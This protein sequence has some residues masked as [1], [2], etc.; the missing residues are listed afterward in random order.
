MIYRLKVVKIL[1]GAYVLISGTQY[2]YSETSPSGAQE[3]NRVTMLAS[4]ERFQEASDLLKDLIAKQHQDPESQSADNVRDRVYYRFAGYLYLQLNLLSE[5]EESFKAIYRSH[6]YRNT[7]N[8]E[9]YLQVLTR[10]TLFLW[11]ALKLQG[12]HG[13]ADQLL[14]QE[15]LIAENKRQSCYLNFAHFL[16]GK[17]DS[18]DL[19]VSVGEPLYTC[20]HFAAAR[21]ALAHF[22]IAQKYSIEQNNDFKTHIIRF[23]WLSTKEDL[24][25]RGIAFRQLQLPI[26]QRVDYIQHTAFSHECA[27]AMR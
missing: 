14:L 27:C 23:L 3:L 10:D 15:S 25:E 21:E 20:I 5:A 9:E 2:V 7:P 1:I 22:W 13:E 16:L 17:I 12:K 8:E 26:P 18:N 6:G 24:F 11:L 19:V 4:Q